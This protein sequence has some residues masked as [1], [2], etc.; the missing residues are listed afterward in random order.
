MENVL[1][2]S[3]G[4]VGPASGDHL[5]GK[6][7]GAMLTLVICLI[8]VRL[9]TALLRRVLDKTHTTSGCGN[10]W[11]SVCLVLWVVT[12]LITADQLG[13]PVTSLAALFVGATPWPYPLA[14]RMSWPMW[15]GMALCDQARWATMWIPSAARAFW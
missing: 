8:A 11:Q 3:A 6:L 10:T 9:A 14:V 5:L 4:P 1:D 2:Q 7:L 15:P 12:V 13:I